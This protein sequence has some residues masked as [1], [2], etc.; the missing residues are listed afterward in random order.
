[1]ADA[2]LARRPVLRAADARCT[3]AANDDRRC[4]QRRALA[5]RLSVDPLLNLWCVR[6]A[7]IGAP[8]AGLRT[9]DDVADWFVAGALEP[10]YGGTWLVDGSSDAVP[11]GD[12]L[13]T[14][15]R[16][17][18]R[19]AAIAHLSAAIARAQDDRLASSGHS[20]R[21]PEEAA[22]AARLLIGI[23][24]CEGRFGD[25][26]TQ[27]VSA[28][29][30]RPGELCAR[31]N[32]YFGGP[33][34]SHPTDGWLA[35]GG[36]V[37]QAWDRLADANWVASTSDVA[38]T[39]AVIHGERVS[40]QWRASVESGDCFLSA[41][42]L[43]ELVS[44][45]GQLAALETQF[46]A[47]VE[48]AKLAAMAEF[49]AGAGH[50]INNPLAVISGRAQLLLAGERD[51]QRRRELALVGAQAMRIHE[52]IADLM[53]FARPPQPQRHVC[54]LSLLVAQVLEPLRAEALER[55]VQLVLIT[56]PH[57]LEVQADATQISVAVAVLVR[58]ALEAI[59]G[60]GRIEIS[61]GWHGP[62]AGH[63]AQIVV[64][65]DGPG[66]PDEVRR[67]LF[68]PYFS[69]RAAGRGLGLGLSKC[70]RIL[71]AHGGRIEVTSAP[72]AGAS[73][74]LLLPAVASA[75]VATQHLAAG[76]SDG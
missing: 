14:A 61:V 51:P 20:S 5:E 4:D 39:E 69:G 60:K 48:R 64:A 13:A 3:N 56:P 47:A 18:E 22:H 42:S 27:G 71:D 73:F 12:G 63:E 15:Q 36:C 66:L 40:S 10:L 19:A 49:A 2:L 32:E 46:T 45:L 52:M 16:A 74:R 26:G 9:A 29:Y 35:A 43:R 50:E 65:D 62:V 21:L 70:W 17:V 25:A 34:A 28:R 7:A 1:M 59:I 53:L 55:D 37:E 31:L 54:D 75:R 11:H 6:M 58:N 8:R 30:A 33:L 41:D 23:A 38:A 44:R 67:H 57:P 24:W 76:S 68:D 72:D